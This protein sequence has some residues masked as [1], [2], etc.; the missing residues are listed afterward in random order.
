MQYKT[1]E[2]VYKKSREAIGKTFG[3]LDK[4]HRLANSDN[5]GKVGQVIEES[6]FEY[7]L[8]SISK[9][10]FIEAEVELKVTPYKINKNNT[11][12]AKERLVLNIINYNKDYKKTFEKSSFWQ[13][14]K[15][16]LIMYYLHEFEKYFKDMQIHYTFLHEF[17]KS[18]DLSIIK[19]DYNIII[20]KILS[21]KAH[22]ISEADT[23]YLAACTKGANS[24]S[25]R[26][27]PFSKIPAKQ[28]AFSLKQSYMTYL[29]RE[30]V[31]KLKNKKTVK[32]ESILKKPLSKQETFEQYIEGIV[33]RYYNQPTD[34][35]LKVFNIKSN[36]K[37]KRA[38]LISRMLN[39]HNISQS[40]EFIKSGIKFKTIHVE[41]DWQIKESMSFPNFD[42]CELIKEEWNDSTIRNM[43]LE[44]KFVFAVFKKDNNMVERFHSLIFWKMPEDDLDIEYKKVFLKTQEILK[45]GNIVTEIK[46]IKGK[47]RYLTNFPKSSENKVG[48]VRPHAVNK[49]DTILLPVRD[50]LTQKKQYPKH[51]FWLNSKYIK[52]IIKNQ[53]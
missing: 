13:K 23:M 53:F 46:T 24:S 35:L 21:G 1:K 40:E 39:V 9:P 18:K 44:T 33:S 25:V 4:Y 5:K 36:A 34:D 38:I 31:S 43:F 27:Q 16:L 41:S 11:L 17:E 19:N 6:V 50:T 8:N 48:H 10:D 22:E 12:S 32:V 26:E 2:E 3:E 20:N 47:N 42:F 15:T 37:S 45:A 52:C 14:N 49:E 30:H 51:C 7:K 29:L 28:R